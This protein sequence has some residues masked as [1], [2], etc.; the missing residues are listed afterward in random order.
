MGCKASCA[1]QGRIFLSDAEKHVLPWAARY[2]MVQ[3]MDLQG[4]PTG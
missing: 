1:K 4:M 3:E 2:L